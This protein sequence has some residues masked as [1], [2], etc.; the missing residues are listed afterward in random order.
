MYQS[1]LSKVLNAYGIEYQRIFD[2]Q[3]GYRNEIWPVLTADDQMI[4]LTFYKREPEIIERIKRANSASEFLAASAMPTRKRFDNRIL[5]LKN[6]NLET[7]VCIYDYLPGST[8]PWEA[9]TMEHIKTLGGTMSDMHSILSGMHVAGFPSVYDEYLAIIDRMKTYFNSTQVNNAILRKLNL[10]LNLNKL[11]EYIKLLE[12]Y[13]LLPGQQVLHMDFV[14]GN[15]L[16]NDD[17]EITGIL[18]FEKTAMGHTVVDIARTLAFLLVDCKYKQPKK[19]IKY[20]LYSG[21]TKR[22][23][24]KDIG[25]KDARAKL[26]EMFLVYDFYKFLRHNPYESLHL[27]E[28]YN[29]TKDILVKRGVVLYK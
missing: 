3:K 5:S 20:F 6:G 7:N 11:D 25:D 2:Y 12:Q 17:A 8:I 9:Y 26:M 16:F 10:S 4:N 22:G 13:Y 14:R 18:D 19:I 15:V 21:Y 28:H 23:Q 27:N 29:R 24:N 1:V